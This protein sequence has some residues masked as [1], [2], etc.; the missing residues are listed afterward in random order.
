M[1]E[2]AIISIISCG[3][4]LMIGTLAV[5]KDFRNPINI[6]F[7]V[8]CIIEALRGFYE[9]MMR[10][11]PPSNPPVFWYNFGSIIWPLVMPVFLLF[12]LFFAAVNIKRYKLIL[13]AVV[14]L[15]IA[16]FFIIIDIQRKYIAVNLVNYKWGWSYQLNSHSTLTYL[17]L[18][19]IGIL[20]LLSIAVIYKGYKKAENIKSKR[21]FIMILVGCSLSFIIGFVTESLLKLFGFGMPEFT[22]FGWFVGNLF[23]GYAVFRHNLFKLT[24]S[25]AAESIIKSMRDALFLT[26]IYGVIKVVNETAVSLIKTGRDQ[27][28]DRTINTFFE[29]EITFD[30]FIDCFI[31][32]SHGINDAEKYLISSTKERIPVSISLSTIMNEEN[33]FIGYVFLARD[34]SERKRNEAEIKH[35]AYHDQLTGL[36]NRAFFYERIKNEISVSKRNEQKFALMY[37]DLDNFKLINDQFGHDEGDKVIKEVSKVL[38]DVVRDCDMPARVGGDEFIVLLSNITDKNNTS[39]ILDRIGRRFDS[40]PVFKR[41]SFNVTPSIG[42][43]IY[44]DCAETVDLLIKKADSAMYT[45]KTSGKNRTYYAE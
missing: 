25:S 3:F 12:A 1:N 14:N 33:D 15:I 2:F 43:S 32:R 38:R 31:N 9:F 34:I 17:A 20:G 29:H 26:D 7:F 35:L 11:S 42:I 21:N 45:S 22:A 44:P 13:L 39:L 37:M 5:S 16:L 18:I 36:P 6:S 10:I 40:N 30:Y 23:V 8:L 4:S 27:I 24:P 19:W 28:V 41:N